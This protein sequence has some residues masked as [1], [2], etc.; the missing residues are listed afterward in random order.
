MVDEAASESGA[1]FS[2]GRGTKMSADL[3]LRNG[4]FTTLDCS[5]PTAT[6]VAITAGVFTAGGRGSD[7]FQSARPGKRI[8]DLGGRRGLPRPTDKP[9]PITRG[10]LNYNKEL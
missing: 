9:L 4:G 3:V 7:V 2:R 6:A 10:G 8:I 1:A 5:N